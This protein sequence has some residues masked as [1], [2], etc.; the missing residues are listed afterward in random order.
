MIIMLFNFENISVLGIID[1][2]KVILTGQFHDDKENPRIVLRCF[3][4]REPDGHNVEFL[5][6]KRSI[7]S[8][9][10]RRATGKCTHQKGEC[11][12]KECSCAGMEFMRTFQYDIKSN[13]S[14]YSCDML[15]TDSYTHGKFSILASAFFDGKGNNDFVILGETVCIHLF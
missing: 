13:G 1:S 11:H 9:T 12:P 15:F 4:C 14:V 3:S 10:L 2:T 6:N 7:D 8:L 5:E